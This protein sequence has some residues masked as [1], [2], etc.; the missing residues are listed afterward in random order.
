MV[1]AIFYAML[2]NDAIELG[3][4]RSFIANDLKSTLIHLRWTW[5]EAW[6]SRTRHE[7]R[8]AQLWQR[9]ITVE[10]RGSSDGQEESQNFRL[11]EP[12]GEDGREKSRGARERTE[13]NLFPNFAN[14]EHAAEFVLREPSAPGPRPLPSY[15]RGLYPCLDLGVAMLYAHDSHIPEM[16]QAI[17]YAMVVDDAT[18]LGLFRQLTMDCMMWA[19][20]KLD[21]GPVESCLVDINCFSTCQPASRGY[22]TERPYGKKGVLLSHILRHH[23]R[24]GIRQRQPL[25]V[26]K[27]VF[28]LSFELAPLAFRSPLPQIRSYCGDTVC[29]AAHIPEMVQAIFYAIVINDATELR[30][31]SRET[32]ESLMLDLQELRW[33]I[34]KAWLLSIEERLKDSQVSRLVEMIYNPW[35]RPKVTSKLRDAPLPSSDEE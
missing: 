28:K 12:C 2:L 14:T 19:I 24:G 5:F 13:M 4:V 8:E 20:R 1:Q 33:D 21:W 16:V 22:A 3:V 11:Q 7:L 35:P 10:T 32:I 15:Y 17:F 31:L 6:M 29:H 27:G 26:H 23:T 18:E 9:P 25:L 30:L 34:V